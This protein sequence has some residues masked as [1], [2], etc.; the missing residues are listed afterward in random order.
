MEQL[1]ISV[2]KETT[3]AR[4]PLG[5]YVLNFFFSGPNKT[6]WY[7]GFILVLTFFAYT[8]YHLSRK[9]IGVVK[10]VLHQNCSEVPPDGHD[11]SH[12]CWCCWAP[13]DNEDTFERLLGALDYAYLFAYAVGMFISGHIAERMDLR[14]FLTL[15]MLL[16]GLF[17]ATLGFAFFQQIHSY[18]FFITIQ[19]VGGMFQATGWPSVV[20]VVANWFGKGR[21]GLIMGIWN[22]HTS[23]GNIL[24]SLVAGAFV[25][26]NWG[27]SFIVPGLI[28]ATMGMVVFFFLVVYPSDVDCQPPLQQKQSDEDGVAA[29]VDLADQP[30]ISFI[31]A[32]L[33]PGVIEFSLCLF[34]AKLVSYSFLFWLPYYLNDT[35]KS[36]TDQQAANLSTLFDVGGIFGGILAGFLADVTGSSGIISFFNL[37]IAAPI[38]F[39]Y[40]YLQRISFTVNVLLMIICGFFVNGPY[41]LI[42]TAVSADLGTH[43]SLNGNS[44][45]L[46]TVTAII[47]GTG[48]IGA[49]VGPL[50]TGLINP[51]NDEGWTEVFLMLA[52]A[53]VIGALCMVRQVFKEF[54]CWRRK[55]PVYQRINQSDSDS[56][57]IAKEVK[58]SKPVA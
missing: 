10:G 3:M 12:P 37:I 48:T 4:V 38:V 36:I 30:A 21:R 53:E 42:T 20:A 32:L 17:T 18:A 54:G 31:G 24:G 56:D 40:N 57:L 50:L 39:L 19:I 14:Y 49:A 15:G 41:A 29:P 5:A 1:Q 23:V 45:A 46:A 28:I 47:D 8:T 13:F 51:Q 34:F 11:T 22:S 55:T 25:L 43:P 44:K 26:T 58:D 27:W 16:S 9:P 6:A 7:K 52:G 35:V 2:P 33:I